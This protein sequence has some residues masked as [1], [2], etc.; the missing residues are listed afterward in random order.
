MKI[1]AANH[2]ALPFAWYY[3]AVSVSRMLRIEF[4]TGSELKEMGPSVE[5]KKCG[6]CTSL[7][8]LLDLS[9]YLPRSSFAVHMCS[10]H[11]VENMLV[12]HMSRRKSS[13]I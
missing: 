1:Y 2:G 7:W 8:T 12:A 4:P 5:C 3:H 13:E 6:G 11:S 10:I 9:Y